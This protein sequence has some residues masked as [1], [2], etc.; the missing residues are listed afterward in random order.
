MNYKRTARDIKALK[1]QGA[2]AIA[3]NGVLSLKSCNSKKELKE[4]IKLLSSARPDEPFL[5][6]ALNYIEVHIKND[7]R[8]ELESSVNEVISYIRESSK[9][10]NEYGAKKIMEKKV[11]FTHCHSSTV[12]SILKTAHKKH[13]FTVH[14]T[15]TRPFFQGR[16]TATELSKAGIRV[17]HFV[18]SAARMAIKKADVMLIGCDVVLSDGYFINKIGSEMMAEIANSMGIPVYVCTHAWKFDGKTL[19]GFDEKLEERYKKEVWGNPPKNVTISNIVFEKI[20]PKLIS[21]VISELGILSVDA[22]ITK[23]METYPWIV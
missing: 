9:K 19:F 10:I 21:G 6:N 2:K 4:A 8:N 14:N 11:V 3:L 15:E 5:F 7:F 22:F 13:K 16:I 1:I 18:D 17:I 23:T 20:N 12:T